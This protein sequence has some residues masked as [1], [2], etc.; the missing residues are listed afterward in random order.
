MKREFDVWT[1][2]G[3][4]LISVSGVSSLPLVRVRDVYHRSDV[5]STRN[6][7]RSSDDRGVVREPS[8]PQVVPR[9]PEGWEEPPNR[10]ADGLGS[11]DVYTWPP[12]DQ[13][14]CAY[15]INLLAFPHTIPPVS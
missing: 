15:E 11:Q 7:S 13:G 6:Y 9:V 1:L 3:R 5:P 12:S 8:L 2:H 14:V 10:G 4:L